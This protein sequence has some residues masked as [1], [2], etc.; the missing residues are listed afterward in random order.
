MALKVPFCPSGR[1]HCCLTKIFL[2]TSFTMS[3]VF[4]PSSPADTSGTNDALSQDPLISPPTCSGNIATQ[5]CQYCEAVGTGALIVCPIH[6]KLPTITSDATTFSVTAST[7]GSASSESAPMPDSPPLLSRER[8]HNYRF[9]PP[10]SLLDFPRPANMSQGESLATILE[11]RYQVCSRMHEAGARR[12]TEESDAKHKTGPRSER[13]ATVRSTSYLLP[14]Q[15]SEPQRRSYGTLSICRNIG[16][17][18]TESCLTSMR[19]CGTKS[20]L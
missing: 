13:I 16:K 2:L 5:N 12:L 1:F 8:H 14:Q 17:H 10:M 7:T 6:Y 11:K 20:I 19:N 18:S 3:T 15:E 4:I 9:T